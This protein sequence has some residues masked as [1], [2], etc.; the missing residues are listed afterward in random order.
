MCRTLTASLSIVD[1]DR[2]DADEDGAR[3][4][5]VRRALTGQV[6]RTRDVRGC[7]KMSVPTGVQQHRGSAQIT[8]IEGRHRNPTLSRICQPKQLDR[9]IH[10]GLQLKISE[11]GA[12]G[13]TVIWGV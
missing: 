7:T 8:V 2:V 13:V 4:D 1:V 10:Q 9:Q 12:I 5:Q 11:V 6:R 3:L